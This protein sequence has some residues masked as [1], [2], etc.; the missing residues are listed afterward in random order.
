[1]EQMQEE[2]H[3]IWSNLNLDMEDWREFLEEEYPGRTEDEYYCLMHEL[4]DGYL[5]DERMNLDK[6]VSTP[7]IVCADLGLWNGR[8]SGYRMIA[9]ATLKTAL[10]AGLKAQ[11][12]MWTG[13]ATCGPL[14]YTM[15][16]GTIT[17]TGH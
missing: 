9:A 13:R 8:K 14:P 6:Q 17:F 5:D 7:I 12:G 1:M 2:K 4:N 10:A 16:G 11:N 15:T 3:I